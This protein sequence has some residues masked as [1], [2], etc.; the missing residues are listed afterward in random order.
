M[1]LLD[2]LERKFGRFAIKNLMFYLIIG[3]AAVFVVCMF[4]INVVLSLVLIPENVLR[5]EVWRVLTWLFIPT[6]VSVLDLLLVAISLYF[7]YFIGKSLEASWGAF[8]LNVYYFLSAIVV[9]AGALIFNFIPTNYFLLESL[10]LAFATLFPEM[11]VLVFFFIP[12]KVK[13]I[14]IAT[15]ALILVQAIRGDSGT[16]LTIVFSLINYLIFFGPMWFSKLRDLIRRKKYE[17]QATPVYTPPRAR[18]TV[19]H[20]SFHRCAVCGKTE[21][22]DPSMQFRYCAECD[23]SREYCMDHLYNHKHF[24]AQDE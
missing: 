1:R 15:A 19:L 22:D 12:V 3:M 13:W 11:R 9:T 17:R 8:R 10:F 23:G 6:S 16:R 5:G 18:A 21:Q 20:P 4:D 24:K 7:Y 14:G 2:R